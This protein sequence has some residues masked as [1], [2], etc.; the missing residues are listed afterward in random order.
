MYWLRFMGLQVKRINYCDKIEIEELTF[1][2]NKLVFKFYHDNELIDYNKIKAFYYRKGYFNIHNN[3]FR[4]YSNNQSLNRLLKEEVNTL[5]NFILHLFE[6]KPSI[7][8]FKNRSLNKLIILK[9][10]E[11]LDIEIPSCY[12]NNNNA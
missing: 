5:H 6:Q 12:I 2:N 9:Y 8:N 4:L 1:S 3:Q 11:E 10:A 7:G